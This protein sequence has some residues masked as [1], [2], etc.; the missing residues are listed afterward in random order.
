MYVAMS[1]LERLSS[2]RKVLYQRSYWRVGTCLYI[3]VTLGRGDSLIRGNITVEPVFYNGHPWDRVLLERWPFN[4]GQFL[5][6]PGNLTVFTEIERVQFGPLE[7]DGHVKCYFF[8]LSPPPPPITLHGQ[9]WYHVRGVSH[10]RY[11]L[12]GVRG[13]KMS[14]RDDPLG[15]WRG[16]WGIWI[17]G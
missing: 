17:R 16:A 10:D 1:F 13:H 7:R 2:S 14:G 4:K 8:T 15:N 11:L 9:L 12:P 3:M 5:K 6:L